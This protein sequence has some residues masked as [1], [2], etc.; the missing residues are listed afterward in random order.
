MLNKG[1]ATIPIHIGAEGKMGTPILVH[2]TV[3][4]TGSPMP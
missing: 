4:T 2:D 1:Y 3:V